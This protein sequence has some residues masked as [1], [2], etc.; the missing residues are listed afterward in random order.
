MQRVVEE[1]DATLDEILSRDKTKRVSVARHWAVYEVRKTTKLSYP[2]IGKILGRDHTTCL[3]S[4]WFCERQIARDKDADPKTR[5]PVYE[6]SLAA[7]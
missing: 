2:Q 4:V 3:N 7:E 5:G 6:P 1:H